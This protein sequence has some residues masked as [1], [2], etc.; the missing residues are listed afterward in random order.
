MSDRIAV[1]NRGK[2]VQCDAPDRIFR[3]PRTRFVAD[4]FRGCNV[5]EARLERENGVPILEL[6]GTRIRLTETPSNGEGPQPIAIRGEVVLLGVDAQRGDLVLASRLEKVTYR[7]VYSDYRLRLSDGQELSATL[8]QRQ[9]V[10]EG[11]EMRL[12]VRIEDIVIL[13]E[14]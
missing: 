2:C 8:T 13:D 11:D 7:G 9:D 3:H 14:D 4:F 5:L 10:R 6:S 12:G 1:L